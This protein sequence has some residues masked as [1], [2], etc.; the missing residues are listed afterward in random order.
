LARDRGY[1]SA[2]IFCHDGTQRIV[3]AVLAAPGDTVDLTA[4]GFRI[5]GKLL[6]NTAPRRVDSQGRAGRAVAPGRYP[7]RPGTLWVVS[8]RTPA[9]F[10]SRYF[11]AVPTSA[12][13]RRFHPL[14]TESRGSRAVRL[15]PG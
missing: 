8:T 1:L 15:R 14:W 7:V 3:K 12:V 2:G 11:G 13:R 4:E 6:P 9:S 10:D 5:Q